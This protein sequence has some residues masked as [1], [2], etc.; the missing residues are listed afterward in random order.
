VSGGHGDRPPGFKARRVALAIARTSDAP[1]AYTFDYPQRYRLAPE[2]VQPGPSR[3]GP[4]HRE[5]STR[6]ERM[7]EVHPIFRPLLRPNPEDRGQGEWWEPAGR[8]RK[9]DAR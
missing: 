7:D 1:V 8:E 6:F 3:I 9:G 4:P 2:E 5:R